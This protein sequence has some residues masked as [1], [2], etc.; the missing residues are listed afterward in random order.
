MKSSPSTPE[1]PRRPRSGPGLVAALLAGLSLPLRGARRRPDREPPAPANPG[2]GTPPAPDSADAPAP[3]AE[4]PP[5]RNAALS[6]IQQIGW[7]LDRRQPRQALD[8]LRNCWRQLTQH[9]A[10]ATLPLAWL[11]GDLAAERIAAQMLPQ[12][13]PLHPDPSGP[14]VVLATAIL[15]YGGHT[16]VIADLAAH[17]GEPVH[18]L[19]GGEI[20][21][22][23]P[24]PAACRRTGLHPAAIEQCPQPGLP[25]AIA[26]WMIGRL[27]QLRPSRLILA[28]HADH[29]ACVLAAAACPRLPRLI[30]QHT[31]DRPTSGLA[32]GHTHILHL[33]PRTRVWGEAQQL[34]GTLLP[35]TTPDPGPPPGHRAPGPLRTAAIGRPEKFGARG[36]VEYPEIVVSALRAGVAS[37]LHIGATSEEFRQQLSAACQRA[38]IA[39]P[40]LRFL[41]WTDSLARTLREEGIDLILDSPGAGGALTHVETMAAGIPDFAGADR[42]MVI[43]SRRQWGGECRLLWSQFGEFED[44]LRQFTPDELR[45]IGL[46]QRDHWR[47]HHHPRVFAETLRHAC[48][49]AADPVPAGTMDPAS[50][51]RLQHA[52]VLLETILLRQQ[53]AELQAE[54]HARLTPSQP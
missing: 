47:R 23:G 17:L 39:E 15:P 25:D 8:I 3:A 44:R 10:P 33:S 46:A 29:L 34:P 27:I 4:S 16:R 21:P 51:L 41:D 19:L 26:R 13:R 28:H 1:A 35:L 38:G 12:G 50:L 49:L 45:Q 54:L 18:L 9:A 53:C 32:L 52:G 5:A 40:D 30:L 48:R 6:P 2:P 24:D 31:E 11:D 36:G 7:H 20:H 22:L 42:P 37:H 43:A 14:T